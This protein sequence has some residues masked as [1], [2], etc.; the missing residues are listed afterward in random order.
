MFVNLN[1]L[2]QAE[3]KRKADEAE[4][5]RLADEAEAKRKAD[6]VYFMI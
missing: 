2:I 6:E 4:K 5:K 1:S 3:A